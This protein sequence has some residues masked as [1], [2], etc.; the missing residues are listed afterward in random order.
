MGC[1]STDD[2]RDGFSGEVGVVMD[3]GMGVHRD[4]MM[5]TSRVPSGQSPEGQH[6]LTED[7]PGLVGVVPLQ[8]ALEAIAKA[9]KGVT[10]GIT[11]R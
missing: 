8:M 3:G 1:E 4:Q 6:T 10:P 7:T 9:A 5:G 2:L 11:V